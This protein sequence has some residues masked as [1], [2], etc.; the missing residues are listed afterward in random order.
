MQSPAATAGSVLTAALFALVSPSAS[1]QATCPP[2]TVLN[3]TMFTNHFGPTPPPWQNLVLTLPQFNPGPAQFLI[4]ADV[5]ITGIV[6]GS[7]QVENLSTSVG[8]CNYVGTLESD[9]V[10]SSPA[11]VPC[12]GSP[13]GTFPLTTNFNTPPTTLMVYDGTLDYRGTSGHTFIVAPQPQSQTCTVTNPAQLASLF[14]GSGNLMFTHSAVDN[15][16]HQATC[17]NLAQIF[18][19]QSEFDV[20][21]VYKYCQNT[22]PTANDDTAQVCLLGS[23]DIPVLEND[24]DPNGGSLNCNSLL[25]TVPP[26]HGTATVVS[27]CSAGAPCPGVCV[28]YVNTDPN[29][30]GNDVFTYQIQDNVGRIGTAH[31]T[32]SICG[33]LAGADVASVCAGGSVNIPVLQNDSSTC[34]TINC[35]SLVIA[36]PPQHGSAVVVTNCTA[37]A[38]CPGVCVNYTPNP[39][40]SGPDSFTYRVSNNNSPPCTGSGQVSITICSVTANNDSANVCSG[41][42]VNIPVLANDSTTCGSLNCASLTI[43]TQPAHGTVQ[44]VGC[45]GTGSCPSCVVKYTSNAGYTGPDS[46]TYR[47]SNDASPA[48]VSNPATVNITVC[49]VTANNDV[50][51]VCAGS[52]INI[53]V[54]ANDST[55][56]GTIDCTTLAIVNAPAHGTALIVGCTGN[57]AGCV[58]Q[59]TPAAGYNGPDSFTYHV[60][61]NLNPPC[62]SNNGTVSITVCSV[63][64]NNDTANVCTGGSV[65]IPVLANDSTSCGVL[66]C[67]SLTIATQPAHGSVTIVG[68]TGTG[69]CAGCVAHYTPNAGYTGPDSFT[70][71]VSN[72]LTPPCVSN[73][74]SVSITVCGVTANNDSANVC[75]GSSVTVPVLANDVAGCGQIDCTTLTIVTAPQHGT[76]SVVGCSGNCSGCGILYTPNAGYTGPDSLT[77]HVSNNQSPACVSNNGTLNLTVCAVVANNDS[78]TVCSGS[79]VNIPVL[80]NDTAGCGVLDCGTLTIVG[81]PAHG[82]VQLSG[83]TGTGACASCVVKY[84]PNAGYVG[85]DSFSYRVANN[86][87]PAC[88]SNTATVNVT[89]CGVTANNDTAAVCA[90]NSVNIP[91]LAN[92]TAGCGAIDCTTLTIATPPA[93]GPATIS[94]CSGNCVRCV[95][96]YTPNAGYTGPDSF[97]YH[98][99]NNQNPACVSN[100]ATVN[101]TVCSVTANNDTANVCTVGSVDIPVLANETTTC[102]ALDCASLTI[103]TQ[104]AHGTV[105]I[106]GCSGS[107][108]C[109][110]CVVH[111]TPNAGY[112]GPDSFTYRVSNNQNPACISNPGTVSV[113]V[114]SVT[115]G[116]D[117]ASV[118]AGSAVNIP[119][120]ANDSTSC[121]AIDCT[122]LAIGTPPAHGI[123]TIVGCSGNCSGC[124]IQYTPAAGYSG[125]DSF[126]YHVSNNQSPPCVSNNGTVSITVCSVTANN[127]TA[128]VCTGS[129]VNIPVLAND[130]T[131]CGV[132][133]CAS[134]SISTQPAHGTAQIVGCTGT[135]AC[136][137]CV[138]KYTPTA[139]YT[140]P[141]SFTYRVSNNQTPACASNPG[142]VNIT[143]CGVTANNDTS[144]VCTN[145]TVNIPVLANDG[146]TCGALDCSTLTIV[147]Q[148]AHGTTQIVGCTGTGACTGCVV[149]YTPNTGYSGPDS[150]TYHVSNNSSPACGSNTATVNITVC[151]VNAVNDTANVCSGSS[152]LIA[153]LA[154]DTPTCG[155]LNCSSLTIVTPPAHGTANI[156][157]CSGTGNCA[158]ACRVN[159]TPNAGYTGPDSFTYTVSNDSNPACPSNVATVNIT[160]CATT[161]GNDT[162]SVCEGS[163]V[164]IHVL[165]NDSTSCGS[166]NCASITIVTP[167]VHGTAVPTAGC[168]GTGTCTGCAITYTPGPGFIGSEPLGH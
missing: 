6:S 106:V 15:S 160:V 116:N 119:V 1:G 21:V 58:I 9:L 31:V 83:C 22:R 88:V 72:N 89:V 101:V 85:P 74:A 16:S 75:A 68:C 56:C 156:T 71:R 13:P 70:Y 55:T 53:P 45:T 63:T 167:P 109:A 133:D 126:T 129:F 141:D 135:G 60:S 50:V 92:D 29:F 113:T 124:V 11:L 136:A 112:A 12:G 151:G 125:P 155:T 18:V 96:T 19:N 111:Y 90:G 123:A 165:G 149:K 46:F 162:A 39:G 140:G 69:A 79:F 100:N 87:S 17:G 32:V 118:C 145:S 30:S 130:T 41:G 7:V 65:D 20:S 159:Y 52:A 157:N 38:P 95:V 94:G 117:V 98:V 122:T 105:T 48:C 143:V 64:A 168:S 121:G 77:Y 128:S 91:V 131:S 154:N 152:V 132:L 97:T 27:N 66:N 84:T 104:P 81:Q 33:V 42:F 78:A 43:G 161:A 25:V 24:F 147:T 110:G 127:D 10:V 40:Y 67:S 28:H 99:S 108:A 57:C 8:N 59:Y 114:C 47:V 23:V 35:A 86:V 37:G 5:T 148:P 163:S 80:A 62:V 44:I 107:G 54:L 142:M 134:L 166:L 158:T 139:G 76:A 103:G 36:T 93:H 4:E 146:T 82:T 26:T 49:G 102:G 115:A 150:F 51:S 73:A 61:N 3:T 164:N 14:T 138:V 153:V 120:L 144:T 34:G 2:G 137:S